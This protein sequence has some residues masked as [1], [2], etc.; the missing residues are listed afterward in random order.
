MNLDWCVCLFQ[1]TDKSTISAEKL[2]NLYECLVGFSW[3]SRPKS[4]WDTLYL[5]VW[6]GYNLGKTN[7]IL[8]TNFVFEYLVGQNGNLV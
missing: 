2:T 7:F 5:S 3:L 1:K 6:L 8:Y 4:G